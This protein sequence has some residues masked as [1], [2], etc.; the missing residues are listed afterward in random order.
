M[1]TLLN[2]DSRVEITRKHEPAVWALMNP[3]PNLFRNAMTAT[4]AILGS[5]SRV[6]LAEHATSVFNFVAKAQE[7]TAPTGVQNAFG[8]PRADH[9]FDI[10][11]LREYDWILASDS[12]TD[13][14][15]ECGPKVGD[16]G[17]DNLDLAARL[18]P[19]A[20]ARFLAGQ[21]ALSTSEA[22]SPDTTEAWVVDLGTVREY[23]EVV[24]ANVDTDRMSR[25]ACDDRTAGDFVLDV[26]VPLASNTLDVDQFRYTV[27]STQAATSN[28]GLDL[29]QE[30]TTAPDELLVD[31]ECKTFP[32]SPRLESWVSRLLSSLHSSEERLKC[33]AET[34]HSL[35]LNLA[36]KCFEQWHSRAELCQV[37]THVEG[38]YVVPAIFP[39]VTLVSKECV[40]ELLRDVEV[41]FQPKLL[42]G[43]WVEPSVVKLVAGHVLTLTK[44]IG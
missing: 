32:S 7:E 8:V 13:L 28:T 3:I 27:D 16:L 23:G 5:P 12:R 44:R 29:R 34:T 4:A 38:G 21:S 36:R 30:H 15:R 35:L 40:I 25:F 31:L 42:I 14:M 17:I 19:V 37:R 18:L 6:H 10:Q 33:T 2:F 20:T 39:S 26:D 43:S 9:A 22:T 11:L 41:L 1:A 24:Q